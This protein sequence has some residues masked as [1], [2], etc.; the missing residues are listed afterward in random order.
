MGSNTIIGHEFARM[1]HPLSVLY[2]TAVVVLLYFAMLTVLSALP[3]K[4]Q[5]L[6]E[7]LVRHYHVLLNRIIQ[8]LL[9]AVWVVPVTTYR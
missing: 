9:V 4:Q 5:Y 1:P 3:H 6:I 2:C 8:V 7:V